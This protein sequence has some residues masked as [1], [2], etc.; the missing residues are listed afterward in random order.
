M[1]CAEGLGLSLLP[2]CARRGGRVP[3]SKYSDVVYRDA[4]LIALLRCAGDNLYRS[5]A[6]PTNPQQ[7]YPDAE[8]LGRLSALATGAPGKVGVTYTSGS[9]ESHTGKEAL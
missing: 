4:E 6:K 5:E 9:H 8:R 3:W 7:R 2:R 1:A